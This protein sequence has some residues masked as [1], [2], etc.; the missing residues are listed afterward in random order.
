MVQDAR[1]FKQRY[2]LSN[3]LTW[4]KISIFQ[5][6]YNKA[7]EMNCWVQHG[8]KLVPAREEPKLITGQ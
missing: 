5:H 2:S 3:A 6:L 4:R 1:R 8:A 7:D